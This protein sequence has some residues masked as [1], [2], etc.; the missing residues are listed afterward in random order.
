MIAN[1]LEPIEGER[2]D[3]GVLRESNLLNNL[4]RH[5]FNNVGETLCSCGDPAYSLSV[6][7]ESAA[8]GL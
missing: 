5:S 8:K 3:A 6:H 7:L 4:Q 1:L 2:Q